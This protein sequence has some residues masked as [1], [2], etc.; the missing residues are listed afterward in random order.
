MSA[1]VVALGGED[2]SE[3][4]ARR[5]ASG[6]LSRSAIAGLYDGAAVVVYPSFYE[7][8]GL[9]IV[10]AI[11]LGLRVVALDTA[12]NQEVRAITDESA[13]VLVK[14]HSELRAAVAGILSE[15][16]RAVAADRWLRRWPEVAR[17]YAQSFGE[18]LDRD[19]DVGLIR[20]RWDLMTTIDAVHPLS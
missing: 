2:A 19:L 17:Q 4:Q 8:F 5:L 15:P 18:L 16:R 3:P 11:A 14:D 1:S 13:L 10:D 12:V 6:T 9:P 7:G 20:R